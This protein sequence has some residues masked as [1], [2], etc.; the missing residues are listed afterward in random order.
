M[1]TSR[2]A[3]DDDTVTFLSGG[4]ADAVA[5]GLHAASGK[6][7][8]IFGSYTATECLAAGL[9]D[10]IVVHVAPVLL[11]A[12]VRLYGSPAAATVQLDRVPLEPGDGP[13]ADLR[14]RIRRQG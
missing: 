14:Y 2:P 1:L 13:L 12:G 6:A 9:L 3:P 4:I 11:G 5:T 7:L 10:E 8:E